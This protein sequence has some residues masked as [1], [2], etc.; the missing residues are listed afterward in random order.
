MS[1]VA[2]HK[3]NKMA[4]LVSQNVDGLHLRSGIPKEK[5][6]ELHGNL[7]VDRC[8]GCHEE[9]YRC[10]KN[11]SWGGAAGK[12]YREEMC[13]ACGGRI[14]DSIVHFGECRMARHSHIGSPCPY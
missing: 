11:V 13:P 7:N 2:L 4:Y 10:S 12:R 6:A 14:R 5:L 1:L 8:E 9:F 3:H